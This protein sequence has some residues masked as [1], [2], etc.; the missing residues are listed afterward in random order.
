[1]KGEDMKQGELHNMKISENVGVRSFRKSETSEF[2]SF[3]EM[4]NIGKFRSFWKSNNEQIHIPRKLTGVPGCVRTVGT[5]SN[6]ERKPWFLSQFC[7]QCIHSGSEPLIE[8]SFIKYSA[9]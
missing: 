6:S 8:T 1:M 5:D 7:S 9:M 4:E 3:P 2:R